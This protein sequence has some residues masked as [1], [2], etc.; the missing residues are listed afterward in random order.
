LSRRGVT[1]GVTLPGSVTPGVTPLRDRLRLV[2]GQAGPGAAE[3]SLDAPQPLT[4]AEIAREMQARGYDIEASLIRTHKKRRESTG[5]PMGIG[6]GR[7]ERFFLPQLIAFYEQRG[8][9]KREEIAA[10]AEQG[11][12][13]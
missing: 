12:A 5:F 11:D 4:I 2:P 13:V 1:P 10:E 8:I 7:D 3:G 9:E 6:E